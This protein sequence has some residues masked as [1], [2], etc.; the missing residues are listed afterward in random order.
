MHRGQVELVL[1]SLRGSLEDAL[2]AHLL[3]HKHP[4]AHEAWSLLLA[5]LHQRNEQDETRHERHERH[6]IR[7]LSEEEAGRVLALT[8]LCEQIG[9]GDCVV[10]TQESALTYYQV[11]A[12]LLPCYGV[13]VVAAEPRPS[14]VLPASH[15]KGAL[16]NVVGRMRF[17]RRFYLVLVGSLL[18]VALGLAAAIARPQFAP[19]QQQIM[20]V[21]PPPGDDG[22]R[23]TTDTPPAPT[24]SEPARGA[25][26]PGR[27][28]IVQVEAAEGLALRLEPGTAITI[29]VRLYLDNQTV[30]TVV[31]GPV[32]VD[33]RAWWKVRAVNQEGWCAGEFLKAR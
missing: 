11:V 27:R 18:V 23:T 9:D 10:L 12:N 13:L 15:Q 24:A 6:V 32:V 3:L 22:T 20:L 8:T 16:L 28:A 17:R 7:F 29:P 26:A 1:L 14:L 4:L 19:A 30:V 25:L 33:G 5:A 21:S 31:D 2:R